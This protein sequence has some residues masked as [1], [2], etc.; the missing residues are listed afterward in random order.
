MS[1][2]VI[3]GV[4]LITFALNLSAL[5]G[6]IRYRSTM[7]SQQKQSINIELRLFSFSIAVF[8]IYCLLAASEV[9]IVFKISVNNCANFVDRI[10]K[11]LHNCHHFP[12]IYIL[13]IYSF[14]HWSHSFNRLWHGRG[15][16]TLIGWSSSLYAMPILI[17]YWWPAVRSVI[18]FSIYYSDAAIERSSTPNHNRIWADSLYSLNLSAS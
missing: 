8:F 6:Y 9:H 4:T 11:K 12:Y 3:V 14:T 2:A 7:T 13:Y 16:P 15:T 1:F 10:Y 5:V 17:Y 18:D